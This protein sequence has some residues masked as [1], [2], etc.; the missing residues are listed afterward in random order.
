[1]KLFQKAAIETLRYWIVERDSIRHKKEENIQP[2][3]WTNDSLL[4][5]YRWCNVRRMDDRVSRWLMDNWYDPSTSPRTLLLAA[6]L[7]RLVNWPDALAV[8]SH[9]KRFTKWNVR[10]AKA[11]LS[12]RFKSGQKTFTG[13]YIINAAGGGSKT[14]IVC[15][16]VQYIAARTPDKEALLYV[17]PNSMQRTWECLQGVPG[18]GSFIAGQITADLRWVCKGAWEDRFSWAPIGPG[19][20]R[21]MRRLLG[22]PPMGPM[23]QMQ[24]NELMPQ[25]WD[26]MMHYR[27]VSEVFDNRHCELM[28][29]QNCLCEFDKYMRLKEGGHVRSRY[30]GRAEAV[31]EELEL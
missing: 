25:L 7:G 22:L 14:D 17:Q 8:V 23:T 26:R 28:D 2:K 18:I 11:M 31:Q 21:G 10:S 30:A 16:Q 19:S 13:A 15:D 20:R 4:R 1:M 27:M 6:A 9:G 29:L 5:D 12:K 24:F 3:P